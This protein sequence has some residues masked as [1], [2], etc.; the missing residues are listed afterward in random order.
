MANFPGW[1]C[2]TL[3]VKMG[4]GKEG[5]SNDLLVGFQ[6]PQYLNLLRGDVW[7]QCD[8]YPLSPPVGHAVGEACECQGSVSCLHCAWC[9]VDGRVP[10]F[11]PERWKHRRSL[12]KHSSQAY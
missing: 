12:F 8:F 11:P 3:S 6:G 5:V 9:S 4:L 7:P 1:P 10:S 2:V